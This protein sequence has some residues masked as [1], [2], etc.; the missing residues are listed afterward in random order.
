MGTLCCDREV[1]VNSNGQENN[2]LGHRMARADTLLVVIDVQEKLVPA[3]AGGDQVVEN[4]RRLLT[5]AKI[6]GL[7]VIATEQDK[8]GST[9]DKIALCIPDCTPI[10][11]VTFNCFSADEFRSQVYATGRRTLIFTGIEAH[12]CVAQTALYALSD[13]RVQVVQD[14]IGSRIMENRDIAIARMRAEGATIT[15]TE[16]FIYEILERAGTDEFKAVLPLVK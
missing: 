8:L 7:P 16:M 11:K 15:S 10:P 13:F 1:Y 12:I 14:A 9:L 2:Q 5:F 4:V 6:V 3:I